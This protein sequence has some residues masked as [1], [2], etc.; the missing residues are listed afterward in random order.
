MLEII[1][2]KQSAFKSSLLSNYPDRMKSWYKCKLHNS[3]SPSIRG[4]HILAMLTSIHKI[5]LA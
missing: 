5:L 1:P 2:T 3:V 4:K